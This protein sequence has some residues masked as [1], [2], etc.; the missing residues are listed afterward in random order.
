MIIAAPR[1]PNDIDA[2]VESNG[3]HEQILDHKFVN[4]ASRNCIQALFRSVIVWEVSIGV[5]VAFGVVACKHCELLPLIV[6]EAIRVRHWSYHNLSCAKQVCQVWVFAK[7]RGEVLNEVVCV[8]GP[9]S[10]VAV[11]RPR[12]VDLHFVFVSHLFVSQS[13]DVEDALFL[14]FVVAVNQVGNSKLLFCVFK[15]DHLREKLG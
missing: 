6:S 3:C 7:V 11:E 14:K 15:L 2:T 13:D 12:Y 9:D 1:V 5:E 10:F 8:V 4:R